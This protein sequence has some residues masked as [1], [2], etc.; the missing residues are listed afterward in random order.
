MSTRCRRDM[1]SSEVPVGPDGLPTLR[2][3]LPTRIIASSLVALA[4][5]LSMVAW[6]LWLSWGL[7][8]AGAAINDTG[9]L[10]M[11]ANRVAVEL[12][13]PDADRAEQVDEFVHAQD[14]TLALLED[15]KSTR[16]KSSH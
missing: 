4:V 14:E 1:T 13:R 3:S 6:T 9:S 5:V 12:M 16:L 2:D 10:R 11:V 15:R 8:G 7:E